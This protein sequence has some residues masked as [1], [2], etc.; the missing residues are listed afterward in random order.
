MRRATLADFYAGLFEKYSG[1]ARHSH[2]GALTISTG[3]PAYP[4]E[5]WVALG[6]AKGH[7]CGESTARL[8]AKKIQQT[9]APHAL[10][11]SVGRHGRAAP[12]CTHVGQTR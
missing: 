10:Q 2:A 4:L 12:P 8:C 5:G 1:L 11:G 9:L 6:Y 7:R 3:N